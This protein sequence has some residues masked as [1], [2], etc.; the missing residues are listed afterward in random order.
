MADISFIVQTKD[1]PDKIKQFLNKHS[2][3]LIL[4]S[5][6]LLALCIFLHIFD[7]DFH[8][9]FVFPANQI[10][11]CDQELQELLLKDKDI[12]KKNVR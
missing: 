5:D 12:C 4:P 2:F 3:L 10:N 6:E 1:R 8:I 11:S 9:L 7:T